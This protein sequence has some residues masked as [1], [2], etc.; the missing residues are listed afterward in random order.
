MAAAQSHPI[1]V[2]GALA[3]QRR[4]R[5]PEQKTPRRASSPAIAAAKRR[6]QERFL[7]LEYLRPTLTS[8]RSHRTHVGVPASST[9]GRS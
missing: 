7:P 1:C 8:L 4:E 6:V 3:Q 9:L 5:G 2:G